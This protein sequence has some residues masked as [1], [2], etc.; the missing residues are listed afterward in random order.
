LLPLTIAIGS[1][2]YELELGRSVLITGYLLG[3]IPDVRR[4]SNASE[5]G[6]RLDNSLGHQLWLIEALPM[7]RMTFAPRRRQRR[8]FMLP[9]V[10]WCEVCQDWCARAV[11]LVALDGQAR[12]AP[13]RQAIFKTAGL[14]SS[15]A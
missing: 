8:G 9:S 4:G 15:G 10:V 5:S 12:G 6:H 14:V 13:V 11:S 2:R 3:A 7:T 1:V